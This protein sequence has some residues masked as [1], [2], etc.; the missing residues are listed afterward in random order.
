MEYQTGYVR[1]IDTCVI[2]DG[3]PG[4]RVC[5]CSCFGC[6]CKHIADTDD[7]VI[8]LIYESLNIRSI[9]CIGSGL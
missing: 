7:Q 4:I 1:K 9:V 8:V 3:K 2:N 5:L 6:V